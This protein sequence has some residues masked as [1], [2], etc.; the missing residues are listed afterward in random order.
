MYFLPD[1]SQ[2]LIYDLDENKNFTGGDYFA[3]MIELMKQT[4]SKQLIEEIQPVNIITTELDASGE[5]EIEDLRKIQEIEEE[6]ATLARQLEEAKSSFESYTSQ[7]NGE[8]SILNAFILM[9]SDDSLR[10]T[11]NYN[12]SVSTALILLLKFS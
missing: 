6:K 4:E 12:S 9:Q 10:R 1:L 7:L 8:V 2:L 11:L 3:D 5:D